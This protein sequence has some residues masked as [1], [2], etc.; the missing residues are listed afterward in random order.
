[1]RSAGCGRM[2]RPWVLGLLV[3]LVALGCSDDPT[4]PAE[5][6]R[7]VEGVDLDVLFAPPTE[8]EIAAVL[9]DWS[10]RA[11][12]AADVEVERDT[13]VEVAGLELRVRIVGHVVDGI[14]HYGAVLALDGLPAPA[15]VI[16]Y[17]HGGDGGVAVEDLLAQFPFLGEDA[18][19]YVWVVP[20]FRSEALR[21]AGSAWA[22]EG[23]PSP[24]DRD[25]DDAL[26]L[27]DVALDIESAADP[28]RFAVLG[29]SRGAGVALLMGIRDERIDRVVDFFG[30]TDFF[31]VFFQDIVEEALRAGA[32][33]L[34]GLGFLDAT[35]VQ[36]LRRGELTIAEVRPQLVRRS[37]VLFAERLPAVQLHHG[38]GDV[39]VGVSQARSL[40]DAMAD[41]GRTEPDFQPFIYEGG[42]HNPLTLT[43]SV[44][45][46]T[47]F[48][49]GLLAPAPTP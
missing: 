42:G 5:Q 34:P 1:M 11:P 20:S 7:I 2:R 4:G 41:L 27:I 19:R 24:W 23:T 36:P 44:A 16:V 17:A 32:G 45:R 22:S 28:E 25:V 49:S 35:Y 48:L 10:G 29:F 15:P 21:F 30:P 33:D 12:A 43:G 13:V 3:G 14:R 39:V 37:A 46:T 18:S 40:V 8:S 9:A 6:D 38:T 31:D 47:A 26:A